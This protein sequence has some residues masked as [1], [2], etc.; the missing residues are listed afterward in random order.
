M[1]QNN[2][3]DDFN[4]GSLSPTDYVN[5]SFKVTGEITLLW[6]SETY[7][8]L[9]VA[10]TA[11]ALRF[12]LINTDVFVTGAATTH[13]ELKIDLAS[14]VFGEVTRE[15][16]INDMVLQTVPF[17]AYYSASDSKM[18]VITAVNSIASY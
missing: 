16:K 13:P 6:A 11:K 9:G 8:T 4:L 7:K 3:E 10:G 15:I 2:I 1:I 5:K 18:L 17:T 14:A 12:D